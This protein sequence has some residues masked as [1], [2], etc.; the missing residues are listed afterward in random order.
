MY[1]KITSNTSDTGAITGRSFIVQK[2]STPFRNPRNNGGSPSGVSEPP[3]L[4]T[5]KMKKTT[6]THSDIPALK[7]NS[8]MVVRPL[9]IKTMATAD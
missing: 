9:T 3:M 5:R 7:Q 2:K 1:K 6:T 4:A 8:T